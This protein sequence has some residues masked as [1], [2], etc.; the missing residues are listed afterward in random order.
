MA[1]T[2]AVAI[3]LPLAG[4]F[5][6]S[7]AAEVPDRL[8]ARQLGE[9]IDAGDLTRTEYRDGSVGG[10]VDVFSECITITV[11][12]GGPTGRNAVSRAIATPTLGNCRIAVPSLTA[13]VGGAEMR[14]GWDYYRYWQG[15]AVVLRPAVALLGLV[16]T[17]LLVTLALI[18][19]LVLAVA[20]VART[21][22]PTLALVLLAPLVLTTDFVDLPLSL[23]H[24]IAMIVI[25]AS[26]AALARVPSSWSRAGF[27]AASAVCGATFVFFDVLFNPPA[28][29]A[30]C[31]FTLGLVT[32]M[33][34]SGTGE[35]M[36]RMA[37]A[38]GGW[39]AGYAWMWISKWIL[40]SFVFGP[41]AVRD[42]ITE[43]VAQR[44]DGD[45][46]AAQMEFLASSGKNLGTWWHQP[47]TGATI[48]VL[49]AALL[50]TAWRNSSLGW[51]RS[52]L[53][54]AVLALPSVLPLVWFEVAKN[55]SQIHHWYTYRSLAVALGIAVASIVA[56]LQGCASTPG[57]VDRSGGRRS[58]VGAVR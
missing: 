53:S 57:G 3:V 56:V 41:S 14:S 48:V 8:V 52:R 44:I 6:L 30:L 54:A 10:T 35:T 42:N 25:L 16:G 28:A 37:V 34:R 58:V 45:L 55:H 46:S 40:A 7:A 36:I 31:A 26:V 17:R 21:S 20:S 9:A 5:L 18:F 47:L 43:Q 11:G 50:V 12:L 38:A 39:L 4:L 29:W 22:S 2:V 1:L 33:S 51:D 23:P 49:V 19:T 32:V 15:S 13:W 27:F 24:A